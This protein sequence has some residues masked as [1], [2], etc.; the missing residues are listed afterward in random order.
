MER[1]AV[2][3]TGASTGIGEATA[4]HLA[5]I[6]FQVFATVRKEQDGAQLAAKAGGKLQPILMEVTDEESVLAAAAL[7]GRLVGDHGLAGLINNAGIAVGGPL[8][9]LATADL[10]QQFEVNVLGYHTVTRAFLPLIRKGKG[11]IVNMA[12]MF[13]RVALP[14]VAPYNA[15][16]FAVESLSASLRMELRPWSI[17][18]SVIGP[19]AILTPIW[20]KSM[21]TADQAMAEWPPEAHQLYGQ[22][23][24]SVRKT[25]VSLGRS[26]IPAEAVARTVAKALTVRH[27]RA[28]YIVGKDARLLEVLRWLPTRLRERLLAAGLGIS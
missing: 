13:G 20:E 15:S 4:L 3:I 21:V 12:S 14:M 8:E 22:M 7:V 19:G 27:P 25:Q 28:R 26:G 1:G 9:F 17:P 11:R 2:L 6:G 16:K 10:R 18:V 24:V 5:A 23:Y